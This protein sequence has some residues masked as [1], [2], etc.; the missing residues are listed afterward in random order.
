M[1]NTL[2]SGGVAGDDNAVRVKFNLS[3]ITLGANDKVRIEISNGVGGFN[4]SE[5]L[6]VSGGNVYYDLPLDV[7]SSGGTAVMHLVITNV[8]DNVEQSV[9]YSYPAKIYF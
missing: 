3:N 8:K 7:T 6:T 2:Q 9:K 5:H 4:S 1:P